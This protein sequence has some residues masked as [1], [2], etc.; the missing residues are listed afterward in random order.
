MPKQFPR[1]TPH[2]RCGTPDCEWGVPFLDISEE[3]LN[4]CY[5]RFREHCIARH[6][7]DPTD[8]ERHFFLDFEAVTLTLLD[9]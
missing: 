1:S 7:L 9:K 6:G 3:E 5:A 8:T 2:L 4:G